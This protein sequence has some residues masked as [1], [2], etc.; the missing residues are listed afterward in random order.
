MYPYLVFLLTYFIYNNFIVDYYEIVSPDFLSV[1][2]VL[3]LIL[4]S[5]FSG[6]FLINELRQMNWKITPE[7]FKCPWNLIDITPP[8]IILVVT[9]INLILYEKTP[10]SKYLLRI[11]T[12]VGSLLMWLKLLY[13][14]RLFE[15]TSHLIRMI[16]K[17]LLGI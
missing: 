1:T 8:F 3:F 11:F 12:S 2:E 9:V 15:S 17:V 4:L 14:C 13:F 5:L 10:F 7:Y 16:G 6:W